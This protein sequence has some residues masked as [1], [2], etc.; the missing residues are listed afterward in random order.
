MVGVRST[1]SSRRCLVGGEVP[2]TKVGRS[3]NAMHRLLSIPKR[4]SPLQPQDEV[5]KRHPLVNRHNTVTNRYPIHPKGAP[6]RYSLWLLNTQSAHLRKI[7]R[8]NRM[9]NINGTSAIK[10]MSQPPHI[11][12]KRIGG[13]TYR[14]A[15]HFSQTSKENMGDKIVRLIQNEAD[16]KVVGQ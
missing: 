2:P 6:K 9:T 3:Q 7:E 1:Q 8:S 4:Y 16:R 5:A 10:T 12:S 14:V 15:V 11:I 13:T